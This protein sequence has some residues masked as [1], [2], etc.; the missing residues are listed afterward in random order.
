M[1]LAV[2]GGVL[3]RWRGRASKWKKYFP[4]PLPQIALALPYAYAAYEHSGWWGGIGV[5][6]LGTLGWCTGHGGFMDLGTW[7][8]DRENET[9]EELIAR[10]R[11]KIPEYWYDV[12]G[13]AIT[14]LCATMWAGMVIGSV[15]LSFSGALK[16]VGY[17]IAHKVGWGTSGGEWIAGALMLGALGLLT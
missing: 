9:S 14:G 6:V 3:N 8:K 16:A 7:T 4:R 1:W 2:L 13:L 5:L 15:W 11:G 17:M 10:L 12:L